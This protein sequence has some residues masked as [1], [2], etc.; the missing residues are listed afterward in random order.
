MLR[1][2]WSTFVDDFQKGQLLI[3]SMSAKKPGSFR[4]SSFHFGR[5]RF[6]NNL[7]FA[8]EAFRPVLVHIYGICGHFHI[9][10]GKFL[11]RREYAVSFSV[12]GS[13]GVSQL[14]IR[15]AN[16]NFAASQDAPHLSALKFH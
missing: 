7:Y 2:L 16:T 4:R 8:A 12:A 3:P 11:E 10:G 1:P 14:G 9:F 5:A 6:L 15:S 13:R